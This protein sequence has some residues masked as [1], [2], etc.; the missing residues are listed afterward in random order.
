MMLRTKSRPQESELEDRLRQLTETV[1]QKQ[2]TIETLSTEK[3]SVVLQLERLQVYL[4]G[5]SSY[6]CVR[7]HTHAS[8][9]LCALRVF[10]MCD[11]ISSYIFIF[12]NIPINTKTRKRRSMAD[13]H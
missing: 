13:S 6:V 1:I 5:N 8:V 9:C 7:A 10:C 3:N 11:M 2:S 12:N 4:R